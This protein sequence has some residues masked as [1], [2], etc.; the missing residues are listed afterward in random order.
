M[1][2]PIHSDRQYGCAERSFGTRALNAGTCTLC[3]SKKRRNFV[4]YNP[5]FCL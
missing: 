2:F 3:A 5:I 1:G 4:D